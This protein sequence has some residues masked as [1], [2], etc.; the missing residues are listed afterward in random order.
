[1]K[2]LP[3]LY[4][5]TS[6]GAIQMWSIGVDKN[7][8][9]V[10]HGQKDGKIQRSEET[11]KE[12][13]NLGRSNETTP[14][15]QALLEATSK[16]EGKIKKGYVEDLSRAAAGEKDIDGGYDCML[17]H[18]FADH[19]HKISYPA[20]IQP[21]LNGHRCLAIV[22]D[23]VATLWSRTRKPITSMPHI[24]KELQDVYP[25]GY[26]ELDGELYNHA[27]K[28][29]FEDLASLIRQT[30][31]KPNCTDV[32][33]YLYDK[34]MDGGFADRIER[35]YGELH[36]YEKSK[37]TLKYLVLTETV[38]VK[39]ED[40]MMQTFEA[41]LAKGYEGAMARNAKGSYVG[42][43]SYDLQKIKEFQ[44]DDYEITDL[45]EGRGT[46]AGCGIFVC[47]IPTAKHPHPCTCIECAFR[48]KM[49]GPKE[50]LR[51]FW[52]NSHKYVGKILVVK[53]QYISKYGIPIFP[54]GERFS[55]K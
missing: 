7:V 24:I 3:T 41:Y 14:S 2:T 1:M 27:L 26:H 44:D 12:G 50:G 47:R 33:Y 29:S 48:V 21:K 36:G 46:Y 20:Y 51:E 30:D 6:T 54:V 18:K 55:D 35:L 9:V 40:E 42:K 8:I 38:L 16:W 49:R 23:G 4:K 43:R 53:Y 39:D 37:A 17:A 13:K 34:K 32:H 45:E 5:K 52:T 25:S 10:E 19:G 31:P 28:D 11:I 22:D 15:E